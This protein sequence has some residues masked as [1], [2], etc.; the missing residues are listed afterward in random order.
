ML[1]LRDLRAK[2]LAASVASRNPIE[3]KQDYYYRSLAIKLYALNRAHGCCEGCQQPAPFLTPN[4]KPYLE[5]HHIR[6]LSDGGPDD[7]RWVVAICP[8]CHRRAHYGPN[9][10]KGQI[11]ANVHTALPTGAAARGGHESARR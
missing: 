1:P 9:L 7:P 5:V 11:L 6:R 8:N 3:R 10:A 2:A 4:Q